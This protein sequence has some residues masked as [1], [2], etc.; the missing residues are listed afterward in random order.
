M[1]DVVAEGREEEISEISGEG[2]SNAQPPPEEQES[3]Q[4]APAQSTVTRN[5]SPPRSPIPPIIIDDDDEDDDDSDWVSDPFTTSFL[6]GFLV[7]LTNIPDLMAD[8]G[9]LFMR[10]FYLK[11]K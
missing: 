9:M 7:G 5:L 10:R 6:L 1:G 8:A 2:V 11:E 4:P 3:Q